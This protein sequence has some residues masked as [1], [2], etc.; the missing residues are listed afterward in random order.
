MKTIGIRRESKNQW[1]RR[2]PFTPEHV[3]ELKDKYGIH[4]IVQPSEIRVFSDAEYSRA[5]AE[6]NEDL[7]QARVIFAIKE[8][9]LKFLEPGKTYVFFSHTIKGQDYNMDM[10]QRLKD[11]KTNLI[12]YE[13]IMDERN[14]RLIFFGEYAGLA[15]MIE[16][17]HCFGQKL[18]LQ[19]FETPFEKVKQ[20]Y[21]YGSLKEAKEKIAE[22]GKEI[23][24]QGL[25]QELCPLVIGFA[26]YGNVSRGAQEIF[27]LLP[28]KVISP[29]TLKEMA[30]SFVA[31]R[32]H[33]YKVVFKEEDLV[34]PKQGSFD[35][36]DYYDFPQKYESQFEDYLPY[37]QVLVNCIY[38][39]E[40][41][42]RLVTKQYI[43]DQT[44][45][46]SNLNL[47][48]IG[49]ISCDI[50]GSIEITYKATM[51][52]N[53]CYTYLARQDVFQDGV[54][55]QG[56][57]VMAIDNLPCEFSR[58]SSEYFSSVLTDFADELIEADFDRP[59]DELVLAPPLK[60]GL[61]LL[62]GEFTDEYKYMQDFLN[63]RSK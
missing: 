60:K 15:G 5:G 29:L 62:N 52:D 38:W 34:R 49:D 50:E 2:T 40:D 61:I 42:P 47:R 33:L 48:V 32:Y 27:D 10:L 26:G 41:Y 59:L 11:L 14:R 13:R 51:P 28:H 63:G 6:I 22:L 31:D 45:L 12:D 1:E 56:V 23:N 24:S 17:L 8:I 46:Q 9:P 54:V 19:G 7:S 20:A 36:Q 21:Q 30:E 4:T 53:P 3:R 43:K 39:T 35:L 37:L 57:S 25:P 18:K 55:R 16:T 58:E 44:V